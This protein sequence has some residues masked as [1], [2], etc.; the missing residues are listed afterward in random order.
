MH[1]DQGVRCPHVRGVVFSWLLHRKIL[2]S[3]KPIPC[4]M[5]PVSWQNLPNGIIVSNCACVNYMHLRICTCAFSSGHAQFAY[6]LCISKSESHARMRSFVWACAVRMM[7]KGR[8]FPDL[9]HIVLH[10]RRI[11]YASFLFQSILIFTTLWAKSADDKLMIFFL[12]FFQ[13]TAFDISCKLSPMETICMKCQILFL[14][15][16]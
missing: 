2:I 4:C 9:A 11:G 15:N 3:T 1:S 5:Q 10:L 14:A 8:F 7:L 16:N 12:T 13:K 6:N